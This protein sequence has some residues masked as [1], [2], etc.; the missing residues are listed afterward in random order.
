[1][2]Q[3]AGVAFVERGNTTQARQALA[4]A[5]EKIVNQGLSLMIAPEGTRAR[6]PKLGPFK[7]GAFHIA[8]QAQVPIVPVV[9]RGTGEVMRRGDQTIRSGEVQVIVL[10]PVDTSGWRPE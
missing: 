3:I 7:K 5:V 6:T 8:M 4:P 2:F 1:M 10:P 9:L